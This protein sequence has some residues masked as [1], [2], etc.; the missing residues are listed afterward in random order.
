MCLL[1]MIITGR[2]VF[3]NIVFFIRIVLVIY[4]LMGGI[5]GYVIFVRM[6]F[7]ICIAGACTRYFYLR[8]L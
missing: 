8:V 1:F 3:V 6:L 5:F 4:G 7:M 2:F